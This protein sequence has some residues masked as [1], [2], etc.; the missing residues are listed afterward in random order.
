MARIIWK[1]QVTSDA[2]AVAAEEERFAAEKADS[3]L[4]LAIE[5]VDT[6]PITDPAVAAAIEELKAALL[7]QA[8]AGKVAG[9]PV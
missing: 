6:S 2:E 5:A 9:R 3:E 1:D 7:G 8:R 4:A